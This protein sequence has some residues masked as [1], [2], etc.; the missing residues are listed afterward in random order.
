MTKLL[1]IAISH[2]GVQEDPAHTNRGPQVS[3]WLIGAGA[4]PG[5]PWC[6]AF[7]HGSGDE[8]YGKAKN[9]VYKTASTHELVDHAKANGTFITADEVRA[10]PSVVLP[11]YQGVYLFTPT[12]GHTFLFE[13]PIS[14][15]GVMH[16]IDGNSNTDGSRDG[17]EVVRLP[18]VKHAHHITDAHFAGVIRY[19]DPA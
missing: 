2:I 11:G 17:Y 16:T 14:A 13:L 18:S 1:A 10:N 8:A 6:A 12:T 3:A 7:I 19:T 15:E 5:D 9:P 4:Q